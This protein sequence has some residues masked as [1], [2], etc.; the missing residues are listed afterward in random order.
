MNSAPNDPDFTANRRLKREPRIQRYYAP[1]PGLS[2]NAANPTGFPEPQAV[3]GF[4]IDP[5]KPKNQEEPRSTSMTEKPDFSFKQPFSAPMTR[6]PEAAWSTAVRERKN[7]MM[8]REAKKPLSKPRRSASKGEIPGGFIRN[9]F[10]KIQQKQNVVEEVPTESQLSS[11]E[12]GSY[13]TE[14]KNLYG[15]VCKDFQ[16]KYFLLKDRDALMNK[17]R[18]R[19]L[20]KVMKGTMMEMCS[21]K[22]RYSRMMGR[23]ASVYERSPDEFVKEYVR[24]AADQDLP[25]SHELR[26]I[27]TLVLTTDHL[28]SDIVDNVPEDVLELV[29]WYE[30]IWSRTRAIRK[31]IT[32]QRL[33]NIDVVA[34][35]EKCI[36]FHIFA[37]YKLSVL[38]AGN[39]DPRMNI[40]N[41]AKCLQSLRHCYEDL[42]KK[43]IFCPNESEFRSY[44]I[45]LNMQDSGVASQANHYRPDVKKHKLVQNALSIASAFHGEEYRLIFKLVKADSTTFLQACLCHQNFTQIRAQI[46]FYMS[47]MIPAR[48][49]IEAS[50][51]V[52]MLFFEKLNS[53][54]DFLVAHGCEVSQDTNGQAI[55]DIRKIRMNAGFVGS[56][57]PLV[58]D[59]LK[60]SIATII[61]GAPPKKV[62]PPRAIN[63]FDEEDRYV[64][65][66]VI[67]N[68]IYELTGEHFAWV[69]KPTEK[70][71][72]SKKTTLEPTKLFSGGSLMDFAKKS[73]GPS[74]TLLLPPTFTAP[75]SS[76]M[77]KPLDSSGKLKKIQKERKKVAKRLAENLVT[78]V[79][80]E[81]LVPVA[82]KV[83]NELRSKWD[84]L[85]EIGENIHQRR[86]EDRTRR[87]LCHWIKF[88]RW[89]REKRAIETFKEAV[90]NASD[91]KLKG[92]VQKGVVCTKPIT[93]IDVIRSKVMTIRKWRAERLAK[94]Y[95]SIWRAAAPRRKAYRLWR[96]EFVSIP[97]TDPAKIVVGNYWKRREVKKLPLFRKRYTREEPSE[98]E[99]PKRFRFSTPFQGLKPRTP[100][101]CLSPVS[102]RI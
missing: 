18:P 50:F 25:L 10:V 37:G 52:E 61:C 73:Q 36:R 95:F 48:S 92:G 58:D 66:P 81:S 11:S 99:S 27:E 68:F 75:K 29:K 93:E 32:Q 1:I 31:D 3:A 23:A 34:I 8:K 4:K 17:A 82:E 45:L 98:L 74:S 63:S 53:C 7:V 100:L 14:L 6:F 76:I 26:P 77:G 101:I 67:R 40:E 51:L 79:I 43:D 2:R 12:V 89:K 94:K 30:F 41:L 39:F 78:E 88:T 91:D 46:L 15:R 97:V 56:Y 13:V 60:T 87:Y 5:S 102:R 47:T 38:E 70:D 9:K 72:F 42:A 62:R 24:S 86:I 64:N 20:H 54:L 16:A 21:E 96:E 85:A 19:D 71:F 33:V 22:E 83:C 57:S 69:A 59:K 44:D 35:T 65:D 49:T 90:R 28:M 80:F 84:R 55:V